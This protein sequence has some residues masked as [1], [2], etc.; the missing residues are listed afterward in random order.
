[1][2]I[3]ICLAGATGWVGKVLTRAIRESKEFE[4]VAVVGK[5]NAGKQLGDLVNIPELDL[6]I[7][8][9]AQEG[10]A[11]GPD[12]FIDYTHP[13]V[14]K[15]HVTVAV[16]AKVPVVI[17]TSGLTEKDFDEIDHLAEKHQVGVLAAGNFAVTAVLLQK[18]AMVAARFVKSWEILDYAAAEKP[19]APSGTARELAAKLSQV[20]T[21]IYHHPIQ[22]TLGQKES[23]GAKVEGTQIHSVRLPGY[24]FA[25]EVVFG[26]A[27]ERLTLR[28]EAGS[29]AEP[30]VMGT[31]LA[32]R[33]VR[34]FAGLRRGLDT[35]L[36]F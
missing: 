4:L 19:D 23:R 25:F 6:T 10:I 36:Q 18:F 13:S 14:V 1:M 24:V 8:R 20:G 9:T 16:K 28:Q 15:E 22:R 33:E 30:Y 2:P 7:K 11:S 31:L 34:S 17:G 3:R 5:N 12:V 26:Q 32:V 27:N 21:P 29:G 35:I